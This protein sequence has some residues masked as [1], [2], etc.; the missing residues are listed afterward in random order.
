MPTDLAGNRIQGWRFDLLDTEGAYVRALDAVTGTGKLDW[1]TSSTPMASGSVDVAGDADYT[2]ARVRVWYQLDGQDD[3]AVF[4]GLVK[5]P[6]ISYTGERASQTLDLYDLTQALSEDTF[7]YPYGVNAGISVQAKVTEIIGG[8]L[9]GVTIMG[10]TVASLAE[11][12][13][14]DA[15][16]SKL[17]I[18]NA[19]L[20]AANCYPLTTD[21]LGRF[22]IADYVAPADR[23]AVWTFTD[24]DGSVFVDE[25]TRARDASGIPNRF[26]CV[27]S[28]PSSGGAP[29]IGIASDTTGTPY[30]YDR[31][32]RW[33]ARV[34]SDVPSTGNLVGLAGRK[35]AEA[36]RLSESFT[37]SH[38]WLPDVGL[39][40]GAM[41]AHSR[42]QNQ[43]VKVTV[44]ATS[45]TCDTKSLYSTV[46]ERAG[47]GY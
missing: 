33:I 24:G 44:S 21:G 30:S 38:P 6:S 41:F 26:I 34:E 28:V 3:V 40:A 13:I 32:G 16:T 14:W 43:P 12:I 25:W 46:L 45:V 8:V 10:S 20:T 31:V 27:G 47:Y 36:Q 11:P 18:C 23:A 5:T 15:N 37:I 42:Y 39:N 17:D 9:A 35:L 22:I 1:N 2:G 4:T 19:L 7:G 29:E